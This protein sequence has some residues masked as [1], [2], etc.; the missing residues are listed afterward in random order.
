V[1]AKVVGDLLLSVAVIEVR[2]GD[3]V[4]ILGIGDEGGEWRP[5]HLHLSSWDLPGWEQRRRVLFDERVTSEVDLA[6]DVLPHG[7]AAPLGNELAVRLLRL[8]LRHPELGEDPV[9]RQELREDLKPS[10]GAI[11]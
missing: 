2:V 1:H 9:D 5:S 3:G 10:R 4:D 11:A 6:A 8:G 7:H